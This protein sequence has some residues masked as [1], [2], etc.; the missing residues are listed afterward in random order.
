MAARSLT[1]LTGALTSRTRRGT[2]CPSVIAARS[3][4]VRVVW[5]R[6]AVEVERPAARCASET[7]RMSAGVSCSRR[8]W[9]MVGTI[10]CRTA[11]RSVAQGFGRSW[12]RVSSSH[13]SAQAFTVVRLLVVGMPSAAIWRWRSLRRVFTS[14]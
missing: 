13:S 5:V 9:P 12:L 10:H 1:A 6:R 11:E 7:A 3:I 8:L 2:W 4:E 14:V